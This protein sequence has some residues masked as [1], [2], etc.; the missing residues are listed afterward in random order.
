MDAQPLNR[1]E[2]RK[3]RTRE[4]LKQAAIDLIVEKGY[5]AVTVEA[6]TER[7]DVGHGTFY[8]HFQDKD[9]IIW[10]I[11][12][13]I[14]AGADIEANNRYL[15][16]RPTRAEHLGIRLFFEYAGKRRDL[17]RTMLGQ[18][19]SGV[20]RGKLHY[21]LAT[22]IEREIRQSRVFHDIALPPPFA[23]QFV[24]GALMGL[25]TWWLETPSTYTAD[26]MADMFY[27]V[28]YH[29]P[30]RPRGEV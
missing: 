23:A 1:F 12:K 11:L 3:Q 15:I 13:D 29:E 28:L 6:I 24:A 14:I 22:E 16:E 18:Q 17:Y 20:L 21:V 26:Q 19:G 10:S 9:D 4:L 27:E 8:I 5:E 30:P 2:R 7:A 25:L